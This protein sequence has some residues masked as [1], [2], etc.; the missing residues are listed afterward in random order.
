MTKFKVAMVITVILLTAT[1][2]GAQQVYTTTGRYMAATS[3]ASIK[4]VVK[5]ASA[6][7]NRALQAMVNSG[8]AAQLRAGVPVYIESS[9]W[10][11]IEI[12]PVGMAGTVWTVRE[13]VKR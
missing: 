7:D 12:R 3:K 8:Q 9:S 1:V 6:K 5:F 11:L 10:G 2:V 13:A 4:R